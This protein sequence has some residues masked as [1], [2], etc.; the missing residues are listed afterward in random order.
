MDIINSGAIHKEIERLQGL[1]PEKQRA[2]EEVRAAKWKRR[3]TFRALRG[4]PKYQQYL[5][6]PNEE[7]QQQP[8][9][10]QQ[11]EEPQQ[12]PSEEPPKPE[13]QAINPSMN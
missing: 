12:Q 7:E 13:Q 9:E 11:P 6:Q 4:E 2:V 10:E 3:R 1:W 8:K 5:P